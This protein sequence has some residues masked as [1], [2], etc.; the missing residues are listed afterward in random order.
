MAATVSGS[1]AQPDTCTVVR[2]A[3][4]ESRR[5]PGEPLT[6]TVRQPTRVVPP[7]PETFGA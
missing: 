4:T 6:R 7:G 5:P 3:V 1:I 2:D